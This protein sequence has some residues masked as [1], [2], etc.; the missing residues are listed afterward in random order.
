[1]YASGSPSQRLTQKQADHA[2]VMTALSAV[3]ERLHGQRICARTND[4]GE[5]A[6]V[7]FMLIDLTVAVMLRDGQDA[8]RTK[9]EARADA[10]EWLEAQAAYAEIQLLESGAVFNPDAS[11]LRYGEPGEKGPALTT[12][13]GDTGV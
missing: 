11:V 6:R 8:S 1:M 10:I 13:P 4:P 2:A 9:D 12:S 5:L 7:L 3:R